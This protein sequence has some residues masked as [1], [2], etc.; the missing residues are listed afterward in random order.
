M[1]RLVEPHLAY[2][3]DNGS[4]L[5]GGKLQFNESGSPSLAKDTYSDE[6]LTTANPNPI[7]LDSAGRVPS[8][9]V[10]VF[11]AGSYRLIVKNSNDA[12]QE[13]YDEVNGGDADGMTYLPSGTGADSRTVKSRLDE[14]PSVKNFSA[15]GDGSTDDTN[16]LADAV[17]SSEGVMFIPAGTYLNGSELLIDATAT[18]SLRGDGAQETILQAT[19]AGAYIKLTRVRTT[20]AH[21]MVDADNT[22]T[23]GIYNPDANA[24]NEVQLDGMHVLDWTTIGFYDG[25]AD[26]G[27]ILGG[28]YGQPNISSD[29]GTTDQCGLMLK[30]DFYVGS[31]A[32]IGN[33]WGHGII[34]DGT[35]ARITLDAPR[36]NFCYR[37]FIKARNSSAVTVL[38][39]YFVNAAVH[40]QDNGTNTTNTAETVYSFHAD[41]ARLNIIGIHCTSG[42]HVEGVFR[43][44]NSGV[45]MVDGYNYLRGSAGG[46]DPA[47]FVT[48]GTG[49]VIV[50]GELEL[51]SPTTKFSAIVDLEPSTSNFGVEVMNFPCVKKFDGTSTTGLSAT[52][53]SLATDGV[54]YQT[55]SSS[56]KFTGSGSSG[57]NYFSFTIDPA[58][59]DDKILVVSAACRLTAGGTSNLD[60]YIEITGSGVDLTAK[61]DSGNL[62]T[63]GSWYYMQNGCLIDDDT[64]TI[65]VKIYSNSSVSNSNDVLNVDRIYV[66][67]LDNSYVGV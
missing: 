7:I 39:G 64:Q 67:V 5:S 12:I 15:T 33:C 57:D 38:G 11:G 20:F 37:G 31:H 23:Y 6:A 48:D 40:K 16:A 52:N 13:T 60:G 54:T 8:T 25:N 10:D 30:K 61:A 29:P 49:R 47:I 65:T 3:D 36:I 45:I 66:N 26:A 53:G 14:R 27:R 51:D 44:E 63:A 32:V 62:T 41:N 9:V 21:F 4:P 58:E 42:N 34:C 35:E 50:N 22:A 46:T 18:T 28:R 56:I 19:A 1:G 17:A 24:G 59:L 43:V 2:L 55:E